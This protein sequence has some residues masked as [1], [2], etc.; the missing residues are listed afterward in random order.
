[1]NISTFLAHHGIASNPFA[2][3]EA[4]QD[5]V[6]SRIEADFRHPDFEKIAGDLE[7][8]SSAVVFGERGTGKTAI[9]IQLERRLEEH[10]AASPSRRCVGVAYDDFNTVLGPYLRADPRRQS[11]SRA[12]LESLELADHMDGILALATPAIVDAFL[13]EHR[14][15]GTSTNFRLL[16]EPARAVRAMSR[17]ARRDLLLLQACYDR[18]A[19]AAERSERLRRVLRLARRDAMPLLKW[20]GL[21]AIAVAVVLLLWSIIRP[22]ETRM[23][24]WNTSIVAF[25]VVALLLLGRFG[26]LWMQRNR[27]ARALARS[28]RL[29]QRPVASFRRSLQELGRI[30]PLAT[31]LP[32]GSEDEPR[33]EMFRRLLGALEPL[34]VVSLIVIVD[35]VD[36]ST[37]VAGDVERMQALVWPLFNSKFLQQERIGIKLLLPL[38]LKH[39]VGRES[40]SFFRGARLDKQNLVE[41]LSWSGATLYDLCTARLEACRHPGAEPVSLMAMFDE[42]VRQQDVVDALDQL[43]QPRDAFKFLYQLLQEH[44]ATVP[45]DAPQWR[46]PKPLFDAVRKRQVERM[47]DM[48]KGVRPG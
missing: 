44:C 25:S 34:G 32:Q 35:R 6:F 7:R 4:R 24:A 1:M 13:D 46:I 8:P 36:E 26:W 23:W 10:N 2:A 27:Q 29:L 11:D 12:A 39:L 18:P 28:L 21:F 45:E 5:A 40:G 37:A 42:N 15:A 14:G 48:L 9:R 22:P 43:Q 31:V 30:A 3:E 33:F 20:G 17:D 41:R 16:E 19:S 47:Q 38:E